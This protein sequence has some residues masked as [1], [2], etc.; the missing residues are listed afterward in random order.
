M[1]FIC[2]LVVNIKFVADA[3]FFC[4]MCFEGVYELILIHC[5]DYL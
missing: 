2:S 3:C 4:G 5:K 1:C